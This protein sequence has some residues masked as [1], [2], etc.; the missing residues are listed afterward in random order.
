[1]YGREVS[2]SLRMHARRDDTR[3]HAMLLQLS[4]YLSI[5]LKSRDSGDVSAETQQGRLTM[6]TRTLGGELLRW[7][8]PTFL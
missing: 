3:S 6:Y 8:R 7:R 2:V 4:I 1:V 5:Y